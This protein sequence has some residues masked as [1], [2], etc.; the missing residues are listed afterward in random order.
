MRYSMKD[1]LTTKV[2]KD[3]KK[4]VRPDSARR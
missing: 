3:T 2:A 1:F 4:A